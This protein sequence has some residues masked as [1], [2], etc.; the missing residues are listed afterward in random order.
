MVNDITLTPNTYRVLKGVP[1]EWWDEHEVVTSIS[2]VHATTMA[3]T[4]KRLAWLIAQQLVE[5]RRT[6]TIAATTEIRRVGK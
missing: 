2:V 5:R 4:R 3:D 1:A 6:Q